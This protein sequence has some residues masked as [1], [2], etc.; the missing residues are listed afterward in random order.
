MKRGPVPG[1]FLASAL[2]W[3]LALLPA[4]A[5]AAEDEARRGAAGG[6]EP[7][8]FP[9]KKVVFH[10]VNLLIFAGILFKVL[11]RPV[12]EFL[13][14]RNREVREA[15]E[16]ASKARAEAE[17]LVA[18]LRK[19]LEAAGAEGEALRSALLAQGEAEKKRLIE[20]AR[21]QSAR[22]LDEARRGADREIERGRQALRA[23][24]VRVAA[25]LAR[26]QL[27]KE[28][29][30]ADR[31]RYNEEFLATIERLRS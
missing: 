13:V 1:K 11:K 16:S 2:A 24:A 4:L 6:G 8:A 19:K 3:G 9:W 14:Q 25:E 21:E 20:V 22:L 15:L 31:E 27:A 29:G 12:K 7:H 17:G 28:F 18:E 26:D 5:L 23:E 30:D 10:A